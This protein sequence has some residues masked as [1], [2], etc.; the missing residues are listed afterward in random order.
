M[1]VRHPHGGDIGAL[2][3]RVAR[4]RSERS[5]LC[6]PSCSVVAAAATLKND[7]FT[8]C[9]KYLIL[10]GPP[11][12]ADRG[13]PRERRSNEVGQ[14]AMV[15]LLMRTAEG[16][17]VEERAGCRAA[18]SAAPLARSGTS[19]TIRCHGRAGCLANRYVTSLGDPSIDVADQPGSSICSVSTR[20]S[21]IRRT[22]CRS[23]AW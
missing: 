4:V 21:A 8:L 3:R 11:S 17:C 9:I 18:A 19:P 1:T 6:L 13:K 5:A 23:G 22:A 7:V 2:A 20:T 16:K 15:S 12:A 10:H 14:A